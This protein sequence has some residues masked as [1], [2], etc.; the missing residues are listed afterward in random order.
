LNHPVLWHDSQIL[1]SRLPSFFVPGFSGVMPTFFVIRSLA[2]FWH[3]CSPPQSTCPLASRMVDYHIFSGV[4]PIFFVIRSL[5]FFWHFCSPPQSTCPLA[6]RMVDYHIFS[7]II[8]LP[9]CSWSVL[10]ADVSRPFWS[11]ECNMYYHISVL[12]Q[13]INWFRR[14][15][16]FCTVGCIMMRIYT[17]L[18]RVCEEVGVAYVK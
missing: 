10:H 2:F 8:L 4:M 16:R 6:S 5:A 17:G 13:P 14:Y 11:S 9:C 18:G 1:F 7:H 3:F 12:L 15:S